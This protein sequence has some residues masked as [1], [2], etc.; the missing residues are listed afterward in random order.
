MEP[1]KEK[2]KKKTQLEKRDKHTTEKARTKWI[3]KA[4]QLQD[5]KESNNI[6]QTK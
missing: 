1:R 5:S 4:L 6:L 3:Q 2:K